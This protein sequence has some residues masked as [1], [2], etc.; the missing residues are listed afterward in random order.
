MTHRAGSGHPTSSLSAVELMTSLFFDG[1]LRYRVDD[2]GFVNNDRVI[3]SK[4]H[5]SP[6]LYG[7]W[8]A[9]GAI[10][11]DRLM[12]YR[13]F[14]SPLEGHPTSRFDYAEAATGSLGQG[15]AIGTGMA[16]AA[17]RLD[18]LDYRTY[19]LL[20]DSEMSEGSQWESMQIAAR[21]ELDN[22][23]GVLDVNRLGQRGPTMYG[24]DLDAYR[25][26]LEAFGWNTVL[27]EDGHDM[28]AVGHAYHQARETVG[29]PTMIIARTVKGKGVSFLEDAE[30]WHGKPVD[31][32]KLR[33]ALDELGEVDPRLRGALTKPEDRAKKHRDRQRAEVFE[34]EL[35]QA[36]ATRDAYGN[37]LRRLGGQFVEMVALDGEVSNSTRAKTFAK[38]HEDRFFEM[39][40]AEQNMVGA[41]IGLGL[42][43]HVPFVSSF[44]AFMTRAFDQIR[45][46]PHCDANIKLVGSHAG[47]AIGQDGPSQMGLEDIA[48]FRTVPGGVVLH[49]ADA[50]STEALVEAL[51]HHDGVAYLRTLRG[52]T[53]VIYRNDETF[54]IGGSKI[55][56]A[57]SDDVVTL[58]GAGMTVH[59][60]L[61]AREALAA[62]GIAARVIDAYSIAPLDVA[63]LE[64]AARET[65][66]ILTVEDHYPAGGLGEAVRSALADVP[67]RIQSLAVRTRPRSG[68]PQELLDASGISTG[69]IADAVRAMI[70]TPEGDLPAKEAP[71]HR[72]LRES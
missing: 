70:P 11:E 6:L 27:V 62:E 3:F 39:Y 29:Q 69:A 55:L 72:L 59:E 53:P 50:V 71:E 35:G 65:P 66:L 63:T 20:G 19:V 40:V 51:V 18:D 41:A 33:Q 10:D 49:P 46:A 9:A 24:H 58:V 52:E 31:D 37:A 8:T 16:L 7:L 56:R 64:Q 28:D 32:E 34:Y 2:P 26:R 25:L 23:V 17:K 5:A 44:A 48:M 67:C 42:R 13:A 12:S 68:T 21:Y 43:G 60:A 36:V 30:G 22:L 61:C 14:D 38:A 57:S 1:H 45:M 54:A 47:V 4:G 15:L